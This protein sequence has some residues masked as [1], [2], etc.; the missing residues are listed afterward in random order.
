MNET[1]SQFAKNPAAG[2]SI[3]VQ[4]QY[5]GK[6]QNSSVSTSGNATHP[7]WEFSASIFITDPEES[8]NVKIMQDNYGTSDIIAESSVPIYEL[9][10]LKNYVRNMFPIT[11]RRS[12]AGEIFL[13][14][15]F[16]PNQ[17]ELQSSRD[18]RF[19]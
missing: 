15:K 17:P 10:H 16:S 19:L 14:G 13:E 8:I 5:D 2:E 9:C 6:I 3:F 7:V 18:D 1:K 4:V 12:P 11:K